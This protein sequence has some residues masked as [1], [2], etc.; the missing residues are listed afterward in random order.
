[1]ELPENFDRPFAAPN[2]MIF[3]NR[4]HMT[5]SAF[6]KTYVFNPLLL[7]LMRRFSHPRVEPFLAVFA[8]F[9]TFTLL[10]IWHG[11][12]SLFVAYGV[13]LGFGV[14]ANKLYQLLLV[15][16][17]GS[18]AYKRLSANSAYVAVCRGLTFTYFAFSL[19]F[20]WSSWNQLGGFV[21]AL[22]AEALA[23]VWLAI[24]AL[25]TI[26]LAL[27]GAVRER[28]EAI[29]IGGTSVLGSRYARA[30]VTTAMIVITL[31]A[32]LLMNTPAPENVYKAF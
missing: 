18:K 8:F 1:L 24:F 12:T 14:S 26:G 11:Q 28:A 17:M 5:L 10:G 22:D 7:S 29:S 25:A 21:R 4:W 30:A 20:F 16:Q 6:F 32:A 9:F 31:M 3:W 15:R 23:A 19:L 2:F 13:V 27:V